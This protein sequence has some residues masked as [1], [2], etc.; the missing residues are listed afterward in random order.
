MLPT[1]LQAH[2][3]SLALAIIGLASSSAPGLADDLQKQSQNPVASL[4]S[5]PFETSANFDVGPSEKMAYNTLIKPVYPVE[6]TENFNLINRV[7]APVVY[8]EGQDI[9]PPPGS[10]FEL[11]GSEIFPGTS[12][13]FGLGN[14]QYQAFFSPAQPGDWIWGVGPA[15][16]LP[17]NTDSKL[18]SDTWSAGV[19][20]VALRIQGNWVYGLLLQNIWDVASESGEP[21]VN[22][23]TVQPILNYN[24]PNGWYLTAGTTMSA[25]WEADSGEEWT[26]PLGGGVGRLVRFGKQPVDFK[27][28]AYDN[29]EKPEFGADWTLQFTVKM[30]FPK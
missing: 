24:L 6:L 28:V 18:G 12:S 10:S 21:D 27:L 23:A 25:N 3:K 13:E 7:I 19:A 26:V 8:I 14:I 2:A 30:L 16:E 29:V 11:G 1:S 9:A 22:R 4:I 15:F 17:T 20:A 5:L